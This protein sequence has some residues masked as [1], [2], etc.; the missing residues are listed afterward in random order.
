MMRF[1][2]DVHIPEITKLNEREHFLLEVDRDR[3]S[4]IEV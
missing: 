1:I 4:V 2:C 3:L